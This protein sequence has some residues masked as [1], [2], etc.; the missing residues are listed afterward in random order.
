MRRTPLVIG[1]AALVAGDLAAQAVPEESQAAQVESAY[2]RTPHFRIDPFRHAMIPHW[3]IVFSAGASA[4]NNTL[5]ASDIGALIF[6]DDELNNP[7][8]ILL[9]DIVDALGLIPVGSGVGGFGRGEGGAYLGG[10]FG[11]QLS[12]GFSAQGRGYGN[13]RVDDAAVALLRDGN[14]ALQ[15]F[16]LG[17]TGGSAL[18]TAEA[19]AHAVLRFGP[20]GSEDGA[21]VSLGLGGRYVRALFYGRGR[22]TIDSRFRV[23]GDSIV[24]DIDFEV[25]STPEFETDRG[26]GIVGDFLL[27]LEW[28]TSGFALEAMVANLGAVTVERVERRTLQFSAQSTDLTEVSDSLD[29]TEFVVQDTVNVDVTLPRIVRFSASAWANRILQLDITATMPVSGEF[30]SSLAVDIGSTWRLL[31]TVPLRAGLLLGGNQGVG[32]TAG[33]GIESRNLLLTLAAGSLGGLFSEG[34]GASARF[35]LGFFF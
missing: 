20:L 32:Y 18:A 25:V 21:E 27:R 13:F 28:P 5:N 9:G 14:A 31:R 10:P 35:D 29:A 12:V 3:G 7:D 30:E 6:L 4:A 26:A 23:T 15:S 33:I 24:A 34:K 11:R 16:S 22:S 1:L 19:G 8:G 2:R 17:T